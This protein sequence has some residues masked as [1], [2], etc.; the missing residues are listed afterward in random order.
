L[1]DGGPTDRRLG[2]SDW[3]SG[4]SRSSDGIRQTAS[5]IFGGYG[6]VDFSVYI[7]G[8]DPRP[9]ATYHPLAPDHGVRD[10]ARAVAFGQRGFLAH[11]AQAAVVAEEGVDAF[12]VEDV[13][14]GQLADDGALGAGGRGDEVV[15]ADGAGGLVEGGD[16]QL[17]ASGCCAA[18]CYH[19]FFP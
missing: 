1:H 7:C 3:H 2:A 5:A 16:V 11:G 10:D 15:E 12:G 13:S 18:L 6:S 14:A 19:F 4:A 8:R 9:N 17:S